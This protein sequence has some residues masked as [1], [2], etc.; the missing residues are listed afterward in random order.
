M[1]EEIALR[2]AAPEALQHE[3]FSS[4]SDAWAYGVT[5]WEIFAAGAEPYT[6]LGLGEVGAFVK[7]GGR[8]KLPSASCPQQV[9]EELMAPCWAVQAG[10]R[11]QF[12][13]LYDAAVRC[14]APEQGD[15]IPRGSML[16]DTR[17]TKTPNRIRRLATTCKNDKAYA[18]PSVHYL[19]TTLVPELR[20][21]VASTV[22]ANLAGNG[23][24]DNAFPLLDA[25][26]ASSYHIKDFIVIPRTK[27]ISCSR[28]DQQGAIFVDTLSGEDNVGPATAILSYAW[29][30]P[31]RL[32]AGAT[33]EWCEGGGLDPSRQYVWIDILCW[34]QH[35]RL[36]DPVG[37]WTPRVEAIG[38]QLTMLHPWDK[39]IYT[40][41][42]WCIFELWYAIG[43]GKKCD[44]SI[45]LAPEDKAGF[46]AAINK[47]G[48]GVVD[49]VLSGIRAESAEAF[50][51][52]DL[53]TITAQVNS[54]PGGFP[55]LNETVKSH[56]A[57][58]FEDQGGIK[59]ARD[60]EE[61]AGFGTSFSMS[62]MTKHDSLRALP[63]RQ[64]S[65][66]YNGF[67]DV[68]LGDRV[69][70]EGHSCAG[71]VRYTDGS[72]VGVELDQPVGDHSGTADGQFLF[73]CGANRGVLADFDQ[74]TLLWQAESAYAFVS[75]KED[76]PEKS[77]IYAA[78]DDVDE[79]V[80]LICTYPDKVCPHRTFGKAFC[81]LH[82]C[83]NCNDHKRSKAT[84]CESCDG[85]SPVA[86]DLGGPRP[87]GGI[88]L[89]VAGN[90]GEFGG[91]GDLE[92]SL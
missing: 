47:E 56:L 61:F 89:H 74:V 11:L 37:E 41:R 39:P 45:I 46:H 50:S 55:T 92:Q 36:S 78:H 38:H 27:H 13:E 80:P 91:F 64:A 32:V 5:I 43:L 88:Y 10:D 22:D 67:E 44:I 73:K 83:P 34:N 62:T 49:S 77:G 21:A 31:L 48:Y 14:G 30:Y 23:D 15:K 6:D 58:W 26:L 76:A 75:E 12:G 81:P 3:K 86:A 33:M 84:R 90:D 35:G 71:V 65:E 25:D 9:F 85:R 19:A 18:A 70:V 82:S 66:G 8:L 17:A 72:R 59:V 20:V 16:A 57:R 54:T 29:R 68:E 79:P 40:T 2:W 63:T 4:A 53:A 7:G 1:H 24:P 28:D 51:P 42:A 69:T 87:T 60:P 52:T